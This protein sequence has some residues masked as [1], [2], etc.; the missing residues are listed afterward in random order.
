VYVEAPES[1]DF[2]LT[3]ETLDR[4]ITP[5]TK[6]FV[7]NSPS[8]PTGAVYSR[9]TLSAI[10]DLAGEH[11]LP[12]FSDDAYEFVVFGGDYVNLR[13]IRKDVPLISGGSI[14]K[15]FMYPGAR[16]GWL[17]FHGDGWDKVKEA[18]MRLCNQRLSVNW[19]M[20][21]GALAALNGPKTHLK[22]F[23]SA[24]KKRSKFFCKRV[25]EI[26]GLSVALPKGAFYA[27]VRIDD[28]K[29]FSNDWEFV[30]ALLKEGVV[31]V[32]GTAFSHELK[33]GYFR[34]VL[35]PPEETLAGAA[36]VLEKFMKRP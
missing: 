27:F 20:Q 18:V 8:N 2:K 24:V 9:K 15:N 7:L 26:D 13:E 12:I 36:D 32:P 35:L 11:K 6:L 33:H 25:K 21:R 23:N 28:L 30:R 4:A 34:A 16:V 3:P 31:T 5:R 22:R 14:S 17:A 19:E 1:H 10:V 29:G